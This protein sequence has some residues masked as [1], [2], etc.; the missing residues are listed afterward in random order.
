MQTIQ[1]QTSNIIRRQHT[2]CGTIRMLSFADF[3]WSSIDRA[4]N[5]LSCEKE[6][7][8]LKALSTNSLISDVMCS[9]ERTHNQ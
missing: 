8:K 5:A 2:H 6:N 7:G 9:L 3:S 4:V 1:R